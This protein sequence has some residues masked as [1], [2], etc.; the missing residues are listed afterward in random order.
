V[1]ASPSRFETT[2]CLIRQPRSR[3][4]RDLGHSHSARTI[5][6]SLRKSILAKEMTKPNTDGQCSSGC[7]PLACLVRM[8]HAKERLEL[9]SPLF[10]ASRE[11]EVM[12]EDNKIAPLSDRSKR[13]LS[14]PPYPS[15]M[16]QK[17]LRE[18]FTYANYPQQPSR[19]FSTQIHAVLNV[20]QNPTH[21]TPAGKTLFCQIQ[22]APRFQSPYLW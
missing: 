7:L 17:T 15:H 5:Q 4:S 13:H 20:S 6:I 22:S 21:V 18:N 1:H 11:K 9:L 19:D 3:P 2:G 14:G 12:G 8:G 16:K 10:C